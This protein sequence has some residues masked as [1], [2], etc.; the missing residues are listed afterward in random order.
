MDDGS[1]NRFGRH[2]IRGYYF[3]SMPAELAKEFEEEYNVDAD[4]IK[5]NLYKKLTECL[6]GYFC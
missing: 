6:F 5:H 2:L 3:N 1:G 4:Y